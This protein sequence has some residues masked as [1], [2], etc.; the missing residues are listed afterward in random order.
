MLKGDPPVR[1]SLTITVLALATALTLFFAG[2]A[3]AEAPQINTPAKISGT[4]TIGQQLTAHNGTWLYADGSSC[5]SECTMT[6]Q[7]QRCTTGC[8]DVPGAGG[9][10][11]TVQA[12]DAGHTLRV[13]ETMAKYDCGEW[14]Y[15]E[16]TQECRDI[17]KTAPSGQTAVVPG[18]A[19][20]GPTIPATPAPQAP[21]APTATAAP[22]VSGLAMVDEM[23][24]ATRGTWSG[25]PALTVEW[26][27]CDEA[28]QNCVGLGLTVDTY[29][30]IA[31][32][33]G[34][35][36]RIKVTG[37]NLAAAR[38]ALSDPTPVVSELKPTEEKPSLEASKV[39]APHK[40]VI[41]ELGAKPAKL[42]RRGVVTLRLTVTDSRGFKIS[43]ALVTAVVLPNAAFAVP[44]VATSAEDGTVALSF[45]S[46]PKLNLKKLKT[47]TL[48][49]T[50]RRPGDRLTSPRASVVR[51]KLGVVTAKK[52]SRRT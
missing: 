28:G 27:R 21:L 50:A 11:Y 52:S 37:Y 48:V 3:A 4:A 19:P 33:I 18:T 45:K 41:S 16:M 38:E 42:T 39:L 51:V 22:T 49:V 43:G 40:L 2:T 7:W 36:L 8:W 20:S 32:D 23:L 13:V 9:R 26:L 35:T 34:K 29:R 6:Y 46:G 15:S 12:A 17:A 14:N 44:A 47:V 1:S 31:F 24:T 10:F 30:V 25:S 5:G